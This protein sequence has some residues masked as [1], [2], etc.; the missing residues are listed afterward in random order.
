MDALPLCLLPLSAMRVAGKD[1]YQKILG[2]NRQ[3]SGDFYNFQ[4]S[5]PRRRLAERQ[6]M[7]F[8]S[9]LP[10]WESNTFPMYSSR[11]VACTD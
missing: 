7:F 6:E 9:R 5:T 10:L 8:P 11:R 1:E 2:W 3:L 4:V